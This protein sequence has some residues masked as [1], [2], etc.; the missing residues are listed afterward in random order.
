MFPLYWWTQTDLQTCTDMKHKLR[1]LPAVKCFSGAQISQKK[2]NKQL[3][4]L[5]KLNLV[6][7]SPMKAGICCTKNSYRGIVSHWLYETYLQLHTY[8]TAKINANDKIKIIKCCKYSTTVGFGIYFVSK[9]VLNHKL[10][11]WNMI[12]CLHIGTNFDL[13]SILKNLKKYCSHFKGKTL[14]LHCN[15]QAKTEIHIA[16][17]DSP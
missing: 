10:I 7:H 14:L 12:M 5:Q 8:A 13:I 16:P 6:K 17:L 11:H 9:S 2:P 15:I 4:E 1:N 3:Q